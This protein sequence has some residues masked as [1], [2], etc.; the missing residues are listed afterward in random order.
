[1]HGHEDARAAHLVRALTTQSCDLVVGVHLLVAVVVSVVVTVLIALA[2]AVMIGVHLL[3]AAV[4]AVMIAVVVTVA[5]IVGSSGC[6]CRRCH[7]LHC[8]IS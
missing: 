2:L 1:M 8:K 3:V 5:A 4:V 6:C 7:R